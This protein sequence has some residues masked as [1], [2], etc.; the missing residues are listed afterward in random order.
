MSAR[1][2]A[3][4]PSPPAFQLPPGCSYIG[5]PVRDGRLIRWQVDCGP[6]RNRDGRGTLG[7]AL[8]AQGWLSRGIG[9]ATATWTKGRETLIVT[10]SSGSPGD[11]IGLTALRRPSG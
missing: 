2:T 11:F 5:Q 9:L 4:A 7:A 1:V 8:D 10:E 3:F 6:A